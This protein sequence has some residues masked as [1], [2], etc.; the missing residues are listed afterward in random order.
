MVKS[1]TNLSLSFGPARTHTHNP[2]P[3]RSIGTSARI[4]FCRLATI[5]KIRLVQLFELCRGIALILRGLESMDFVILPLAFDG[6]RE[7]A[8]C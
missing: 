4:A 1:N 2:S 8:G 6:E 3:D 5:M 7:R